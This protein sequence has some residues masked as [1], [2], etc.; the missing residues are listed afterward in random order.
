MHLDTNHTL[1]LKL[2][3]LRAA[4][5]RGV[6]WWHTGSVDYGAADGQAEAMWDAMSAFAGP[7]AIPP[8]PFT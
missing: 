6:A 8:P 1:T 7:H 2:Q 4:G 5:A 3:A